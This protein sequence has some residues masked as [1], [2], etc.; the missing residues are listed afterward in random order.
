MALRTK[1][2]SNRDAAQPLVKSL[3]MGN[4]RNRVAWNTISP[5]SP[6][7]PMAVTDPLVLAIFFQQGCG[8]Q[9]F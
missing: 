4:S 2:H 7:H 9:R 8:Q 1:F 6:L 5:K 3:N